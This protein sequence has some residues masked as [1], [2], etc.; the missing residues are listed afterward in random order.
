MR[1][2]R[3]V[4]ALEV[5]QVPDVHSLVVRQVEP[6]LHRQEAVDAALVCELGGVVLDV[7]RR[8]RCPSCVLWLALHVCVSFIIITSL[9]NALIRIPL[10]AY[11]NSILRL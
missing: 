3:L 8:R 4:S 5:L 2:Y 11:R 10:S 7:H 6:A 9:I 1:T